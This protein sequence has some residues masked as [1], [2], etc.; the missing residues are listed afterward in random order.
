MG[1]EEYDKIQNIYKQLVKQENTV[2]TCEKELG[3]L[4]QDLLLCTGVFQGKRRKELQGQI[5]AKEQQTADAK[6]RLGDI[7]RG[8]GYPSVDDFMRIYRNTKADYTD[9]IKCLKEWGEKYGM[10]YVEQ[11]FKERKNLQYVNCFPKI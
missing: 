10:L 2:L 8:Y 4:R 7:V 1:M 9:Y 5:T 11:A 3:Q 6:Q